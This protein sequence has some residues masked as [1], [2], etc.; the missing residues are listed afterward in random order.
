MI[1]TPN[2]GQ[3]CRQCRHYEESHPYQDRFFGKM[4]LKDYCA[5]QGHRIVI[6]NG[7]CCPLF[8]KRLYSS[9]SK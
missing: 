1:D 5:K 7:E 4:Y 8:L 6:E 3:T 2:A 9:D